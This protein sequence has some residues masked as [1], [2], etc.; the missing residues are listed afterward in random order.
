MRFL[1]AA[2]VISGLGAVAPVNSTAAQQ[3]KLP[4]VILRSDTI[5]RDL[6]L[7]A[8]AAA[9]VA[10]DG[11]L[12]L[13]DYSNLS[14]IRISSD[15]EVLWRTGQKGKG[16]G[17]FE[18]PLRVAARVEGGAAV[19]DAGLQ[20]VSF[21][22]RKGR[23]EWSGRPEIDFAQVDDI[24]ILAESS[25]VIISGVV[26]PLTGAPEDALK[27]G[28]HILD[29][30]LRHIRSFAPLPDASDPAVLPF[31]GAGHVSLASFGLWYVRKLPYE[32]YA[33]DLRG[34]QLRK[35]LVRPNL[36]HRPDDFLSFSTRPEHGIQGITVRRTRKDVPAPAR[37]VEIGNYL[38]TG[39]IGRAAETK[40]LDIVHGTTGRVLASTPM[41]AGWLHIVGYYRPLSL[42]W[43]VAETEVGHVLLRQTISL[44]Q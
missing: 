40:S 31:W 44:H 27:H 7:G 38:L 11:G 13:L 23:F 3:L 4:W 21:F 9:T 15:G 37:P 12:F 25:L 22:D 32:L 19:Y 42:L 16:P 39:L 34:N 8:I 28:V 18:R 35:H 30:S 36:A 41:P 20:T 17:D 33:F 5:G 6:V 26:R 1:L 24:L 2:W 10:P 29:R 14:L 43:I